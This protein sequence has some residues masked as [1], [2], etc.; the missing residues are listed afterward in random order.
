MTT[1]RIKKKRPKLFNSEV[2]LRATRGSMYGRYLITKATLLS[3]SV[4]G[5]GGMGLHLESLLPVC[6]QAS[7]I[8]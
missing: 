3:S 5:Q 6:A 8:D 4:G 7:R 1:V 2:N